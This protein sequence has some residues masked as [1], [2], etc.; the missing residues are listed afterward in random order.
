MLHTYFKSLNC[1]KCNNKLR[2]KPLLSITF[3]DYL[4]LR[5][6]NVSYCWDS[7][8]RDLLKFIPEYFL[9]W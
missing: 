3:T 4:N 9:D 8:P 6:E 5:L 2:T 1:L 7:C